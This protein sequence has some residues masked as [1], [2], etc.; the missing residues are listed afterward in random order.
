TE[1]EPDYRHAGIDIFLDP[2]AHGAGL[3]TDAVRTLAVHLVDDHGP[4][5]LGID[6][7]ADY[8]T[9]DIPLPPGAVLALY[10]DGLVEHPGTDIDDAI[11]D[12]ADQLAAAD[13]GDLDVLADSLIHHAERTAPRHDDIAL[14]LI[15][16]QNHP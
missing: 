9:A 13:P 5:R 14:L 8:S 16:P 4:H 12:L 2:A 10:T 7:A 6:P 15:H 11:D 1:D 3:G